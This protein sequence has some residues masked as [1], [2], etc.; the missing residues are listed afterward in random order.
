MLFL[1]V[2]G[3]HARISQTLMAWPKGTLAYSTA[4]D[5]PPSLY[6][7]FNSKHNH[8][9]CAD[10]SGTVV[11]RYIR[12]FFATST[13]EYCCTVIQHLMELMDRRVYTRTPR[14][15]CVSAGI[16]SIFVVGWAGVFFPTHASRLGSS[17]T[18]SQP[19][20]IG[21]LFPSLFVTSGGSA[22]PG[23]S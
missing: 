21:R 15:G 3:C 20:L 10:I 7:V 1:H 11:I 5:Q 23:P 22:P 4:L 17:L 2:I 12:I 8:I 13:F 6:Q 16:H 9:R 14:G 18:R 19:A